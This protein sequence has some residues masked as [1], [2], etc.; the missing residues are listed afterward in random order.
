MNI[1]KKIIKIIISVVYDIIVATAILLF[2]YWV[3][4]VGME[5]NNYRIKPNLP[6][7]MYKHQRRRFF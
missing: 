2:V 5:K 7:K 4:Q 3:S 1:D 6:H